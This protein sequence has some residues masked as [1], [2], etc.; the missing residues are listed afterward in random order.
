MNSAGVQRGKEMRKRPA[1]DA[2]VQQ[3]AKK[4]LN[5][6]NEL[7]DLLET[8][9]LDVS[10]AKNE[11][12]TNS[13]L[14]AKSAARENREQ[15]RGNREQKRGNWGPGV[16]NQELGVGNR[17]QRAG[18]K[19]QRKC[20]REEGIGNGGP[21]PLTQL[22]WVGAPEKRPIGSHWCRSPVPY[23]LFP[24]LGGHKSP[25]QDVGCDKQ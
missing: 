19:G 7:R 4:M 23:P 3:N 8:K 13:V 2:K 11:L 18:N 22:G 5:R 15:G 16:G 1:G 9:D 10:C 20:S 12:K 24:A 25:R 6:G 17:E 21:V 14:S